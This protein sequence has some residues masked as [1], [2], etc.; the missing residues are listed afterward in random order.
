MATRFLALSV[1]VTGTICNDCS[2]VADG[3]QDCST[4]TSSSHSQLLQV[5]VGNSRLHE[6]GAAAAHADSTDV[7]EVDF[8]GNSSQAMLALIGLLQDPNV[9][10]LFK[11]DLQWHGDVFG[12]AKDRDEYSHMGLSIFTG[13]R[14]NDWAVLLGVVVFL[15]LVDCVCLRRCCQGNHTQKMHFKLVAFWIGCGVVYNFIVLVRNGRDSAIQWCSG[16]FLEWLLSMDNLFVFHLVFDCFKTPA[17]LLHKALFF[18]ITGAIVFRMGFFLALSKLLHTLHWMRFVF[19]AILI[20]SGIQAARDD[21]EELDVA[22]M[23]V[24]RMLKKALGTRLVEKYDLDKH[25]FF[26]YDDGQYRATLLCIVIFCLEM[27]DILFAVDSVSAKVA[28]IPDYYIAYSSSVLAMF[29]LR[30]M[31]FIIRDLVGMFDMLKYGLCFILVFIGFELVL[32]DYVVLPAQV[33]C[34]L[35]VSVFVVCTL[36]P[37]AQSFYLQRTRTASDQAREPIG[38]ADAPQE[39]TG[40]DKQISELS[41]DQD[42]TSTDTTSRIATPP[43]SADNVQS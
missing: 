15:L 2:I 40:F 30:S 6:W 33:V 20:Y 13:P 24:V 42:T 37:T 27:T 10:N 35:L 41:S 34:V 25:G 22:D 3:Q 32:E 19:G 38:A 7:G 1:M 4:T 11:E 43:P 23:F 8:S 18:G 5:K 36:G 26:M 9:A 21:D 28:Q 39:A 12:D 16:Y 31:F 14:K 17:E 29:G